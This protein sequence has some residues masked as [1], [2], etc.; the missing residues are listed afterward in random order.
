MNGFKLKCGRNQLIAAGVHFN[1][2]KKM[3]SNQQISSEMRQKPVMATGV[4][5]T[6]VRK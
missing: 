2:H 1:V 3:I 5:F 4:H 6:S